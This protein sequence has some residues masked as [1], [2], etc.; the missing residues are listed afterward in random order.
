MELM[1]HMDAKKG[2]FPHEWLRACVHLHARIAIGR[3]PGKASNTAKHGSPESTTSH[4]QAKVADRRDSYKGH[5]P[6]LKAY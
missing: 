3:P 6:Q 1:K 4:R 5:P 2:Y